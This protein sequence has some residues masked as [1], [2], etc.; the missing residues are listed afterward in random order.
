M[1]A[2]SA[3][4]ETLPWLTSETLPWLKAAVNDPLAMDKKAEK[5]VETGLKPESC[6]MPDTNKTLKLDDV[7]I[8][9]L[10]G[11][12]ETRAAYL[13]LV[14]QASSYATNYSSY[15]PSVTAT[16]DRDRTGTFSGTSK[17]TDI[18]RNHGL[19]LGLTLYDFGQREFKLEAAE[20]TLI[21]AGY[22]YNSTLQGTIASALQAYY[23]LLTAQNAVTV[24]KDAEKFAQESYEAA[25]LR[26]DIGQ[27]PLADKLQAK[28]VYSQS[29][30][31]SQVAENSL[32]LQKAVM[33]KLMGLSADAP[34]VVAEIDN[35]T[36]AKDPFGEEIKT[37]M[38]KA[39]EQRKDLQ[40]TRASIK[41]SETS[42]KALERANTATVSVTANMSMDNDEVNVFS[43]TSDRTQA[44]GLSVS[45]PIFTGFNN[46]Y[47]ERNAKKLLESQRASLEK[48]E[49]DVEQDVWNAWHNYETAKRSWETSQDQLKS[50]IELKNVALGRYK[51]G[52]GSI[53]DVLNAKSQYSSALQSHLVTRQNLLTTRVDLIR[54]VGVL[55]LE[56]MQPSKVLSH[57]I[58]LEEELQQ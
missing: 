47:N 5:L 42:L 4:A 43:R 39:K 6:Q 49:L 48:R 38:S 22:N 10:C 26:Y 28:G 17:S 12:P 20:Q 33:A 27:V 57:N 36:L 1:S 52:L 14:A 25:V 8:A 50:A 2:G 56:T 41:A 18:N 53:L 31:D 7:V 54:S 37:L 58:N 19:D 16:I 35:K 3:H 15:L 51:E 44:V 32:S 24:A 45:I 21:S 30:L 29:L 23:N 9:T 13:S 11:N 40:A 46:T 34:V 55:N